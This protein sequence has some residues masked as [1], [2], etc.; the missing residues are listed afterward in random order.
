MLHGTSIRKVLN[1]FGHVRA[2]LTHRHVNTVDRPKAL[3]PLVLFIDPGIVD[4]GVNRHSR[5]TGLT[6][7]NDQLTLATTNRD[8]RIHRHNPCLH[9][10]THRLPINDPSSNFF[11]RISLF[12]G[13]FSFV[14][15][16]MTQRIHYTTQKPFTHRHRK[17][18][19]GSAHLSAF[20][21]ARVIAKNHRSHLGFLQV[22]RQPAHSVT[23]VEPLV[24]HCPGQAFYLGHP[25]ADL[26]NDPHVL[27]RNIGF[28]PGNLGF[29][30]LQ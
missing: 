22:K 20:V 4:Y 25:V 26:A 30:I 24:H 11:N 17:K 2:F 3:V 12:M 9:W 5:L 1:H 19:S 13:H 10:L 27:A 23:K 6:I 28:G 16:R 15:N 8:H 14:V 29:N 7:P 18:F 21:D